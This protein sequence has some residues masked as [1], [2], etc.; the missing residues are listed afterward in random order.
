M[1]KLPSLKAIQTFETTARHLSF[2][3]AADELCISQSAVSHQIKSLEKTLGKQLFFRNNNQVSL[4]CYGDSLYS[5]AKDSFKRL[6]A[7]TSNLI[8]QNDEQIKVMAQS[9]IAVDWLAP[10]I[11]EFHQQH[12]QINVMLSLAVSDLDFDASDFDIVIGTWPVPANFFTQKIRFENWYPIC[13]PNIYDQI[14]PQD[15]SSLISQTLFSSENGQDWELWIQNHKPNMTRPVAMQYFSNTILSYK[16]ALSGLG[17]ALTCDFLAHD[18]INHG[19]LKPIRNLSYELPWGHFY[20][21]YRQARHSAEQ[22]QTFINW[23]ME[24]CAP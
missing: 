22:L 6:Q 2:S 21:H 9:A 16:A 1:K 13:S 12:P 23:L 10:R 5:V 14:N 18:A 7:V 20:I 11:A 17:I 3:R 19:L 15:P 24:I 8:E 4:T